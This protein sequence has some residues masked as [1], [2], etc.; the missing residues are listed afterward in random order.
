M[1]RRISV[2]L[3]GKVS[4]KVASK[5]TGGH[6]HTHT[7]QD[8]WERIRADVCIV[9]ISYCLNRLRP[10]SSLI[11]VNIIY[12]TNHLLIPLKRKNNHIILQFIYI[13]IYA[14]DEALTA[15]FKCIVVAFKLS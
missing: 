4:H 5:A 14:Y 10:S 1:S 12:E 7:G 3:L 6:T 15:P 11:P 9:A 13:Y 2:F 8:M